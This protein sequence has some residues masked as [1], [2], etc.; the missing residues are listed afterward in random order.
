MSESVCICKTQWAR[1]YGRIVCT[2]SLIA[3]C[4]VCA[5]IFTCSHQHTNNGIHAA[6][7]KNVLMKACRGYYL[8]WAC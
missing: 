3:L 5:H 2:I 1:L 8:S 7:T 4:Y 6:D